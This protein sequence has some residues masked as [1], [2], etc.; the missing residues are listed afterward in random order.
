MTNKLFT[1]TLLTSMTVAA[2]IVSCVGGLV[3]AA[4]T[5]PEKSGSDDDDGETLE[6]YVVRL[7]RELHKIPETCFSEVRRGGMEQKKKKN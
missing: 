3:A 5:T 7:R 1:A 6:E 4:A 2:A